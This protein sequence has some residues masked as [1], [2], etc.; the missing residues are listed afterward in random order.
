MK[1]KTSKATKKQQKLNDDNF[2]M[3]LTINE[4][5]NGYTDN[6]LNGLG[7]LEFISAQ[8][9]D[10]RKE[11]DGWFYA[12]QKH[13]L[14]ETEMSLSTWKRCV[15]RYI[16]DGLIEYKHGDRTENGAMSSEFKLL[17]NITEVDIYNKGVK[18]GVQTLQHT[19]NQRGSNDNI[20]NGNNT[21]TP[22]NTENRK[23]NSE[24]KNNN[25]Y[26]DLKDE[27]NF[28]DLKRFVLRFIDTTSR[29]EAIELYKDYTQTHT[30]Q[31]D[32]MEFLAT[33]TSKVADVKGWEKTTTTKTNNSSRVEVIEENTNTSSFHTPSE[34]AFLD[35]FEEEV[36]EESTPT[37][38]EPKNDKRTSGSDLKSELAEEK[39][40]FKSVRVERFAK[41][42]EVMNAQ[43]EETADM[44]MAS[45]IEGGAVQE[46]FSRFEHYIPT[47]VQEQVAE[48]VEGW[49][50]YK[51]AII[52]KREAETF[53]MFKGEIEKVAELTEWNSL[54]G[55]EQEVVFYQSITPIVLKYYSTS[56]HAV[57]QEKANE[58]VQLMNDLKMVA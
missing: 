4:K 46:R 30:L 49:L 41:W 2:I 39:E 8:F 21:V 24:V 27:K 17:W 56:T 31:E 16:N 13:I 15:R 34:I 6:M 37:E 55:E 18:Q 51:S 58:A 45:Y 38:N 47:I 22:Q 28:E 32:E 57:Q 35:G 23:K 26:I 12:D 3:C 5:M 50:R 19:D 42:A 25:S 11:H 7:Y 1:Q 48:V 10:Y 44:C 52:R 14:S 36:E 40:N 20:L 53:N 33:Y 54:T 9:T 43:G 29:A